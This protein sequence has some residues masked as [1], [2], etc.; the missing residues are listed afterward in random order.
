MS[1]DVQRKLAN[2]VGRE[3]HFERYGDTKPY[4]P[5]RE[6]R[7][8]T[9]AEREQTLRR[10]GACGG[11]RTA[12]TRTVRSVVRTAAGMTSRHA[13][14]WRGPS[15]MVSHQTGPS[16]YVNHLDEQDLRVDCPLCP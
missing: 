4:L 15:L 2:V 16:T 13:R 6:S 11:S 8:T 5:V 12:R 9:A 3:R 7:G 10:V 1:W 14:E